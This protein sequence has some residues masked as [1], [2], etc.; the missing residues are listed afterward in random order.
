MPVGGR[1]PLNAAPATG[2][3]AWG[4]TGKIVKNSRGVCPTSRIRVHEKGMKFGLWVD[5]VVVDQRLVPNEI[6]HKWVGQKDGRDN[7]LRIPG[8]EAPVVH[9]CPGKP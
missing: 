3:V 9:I 5:P 1:D 4:V 6:P 7:V 2:D 8:W